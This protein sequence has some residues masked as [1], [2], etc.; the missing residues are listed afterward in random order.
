MNPQHAKQCAANCAAIINIKSDSDII[1]FRTQTTTKHKALEHLC[2]EQGI[3]YPSSE[4]GTHGEHM[5]LTSCE[6]WKK[7]LKRAKARHIEADQLNG[8]N[9]K[10]LWLAKSENRKQAQGKNK[11][12]HYSYVSDL[13]LAMHRANKE[14]LKAFIDAAQAMCEDG[15]I[16]GLK[17]IAAASI[18]NPVCRR[19]ELMT[20]IRGFEEWA[21]LKGH[22]CRF[23][24]F[25]APSKYHATSKKY[26]QTTP[27][28]CQEYMVD[29]F[30][31]GRAKVS[32]QH[33]KPY[34]FRVT[35]PHRDGTP[36]WHLLLWF[37]DDAE[38]ARY[39]AIMTNYFL[40]EDGTERGAQKNRVKTIVIDMVEGSAVGYIAKYIAKN[41]D[42]VYQDGKTKFDA[43]KSKGLDSVEVSERVL[44]FASLWSIRQFQQI[45]GVKVGAWREL[46]R[47][48]DAK[49]IAALPDSVKAMHKAADEGDWQ[50]FIIAAQDKH[51]RLLLE[52]SKDL[53]QAL[54]TEHGTF[55][56]IPEAALLGALNQWQEPSVKRLKGV[57][58]DGFQLITHKKLWTISIKTSIEKRHDSLLLDRDTQAEN[59]FINSYLK[60]KKVPIK[61]LFKSEADLLKHYEE[62]NYNGGVIKELVNFVYSKHTPKAAQNP[63]KALD[64]MADFHDKQ[65]KVIKAITPK[66]R[67]RV[68]A[69]I[70]AR[71]Y[72]G[73]DAIASTRTCGNNCTGV[74]T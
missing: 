9:R 70:T 32:R 20:R 21:K 59:D 35:E 50:A 15:T 29:V 45:G 72:G 43:K 53:L 48:R 31:K 10:I 68:L 60:N 33:I 65:P 74:K 6:W 57:V 46:R 52:T 51:I 54:V 22:V 13:S 66:E 67:D 42:G 27:K 47:V 3:V 1:Q 28:E 25:T 2:S 61:L 49:Q 64:A 37:K 63:F 34:G 30:A 7:Q 17:Q 11:S 39:E 44:A 4:F 5:R 26:N 71:S 14:Q 58:I 56:D 62:N 69:V 40:K 18:S 16:I 41:I 24:T 23:F 12:L 19:A 73:I 36:H 55:E 38:A 8:L